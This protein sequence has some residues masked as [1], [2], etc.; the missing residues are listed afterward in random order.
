[1]EKGGIITLVP[2]V[3]IKLFKDALKDMSK[4]DLREKKGAIVKVVLDSCEWIELFT[5]G[6]MAE[7]CAL[8][9]R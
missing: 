7:P 9:C 3:P 6:P 1:M 4:T 2:E 8:S 5:G